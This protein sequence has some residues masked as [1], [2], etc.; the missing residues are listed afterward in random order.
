MPDRMQ[1][2]RTE[3]KDASVARLLAIAGV[4]FGVVFALLSC[5]KSEPERTSEAQTEWVR[6]GG[7]EVGVQLSSRSIR[8]SERLR[9]RLI[10]QCEPS[11]A[12]RLPELT[13]NL[14]SFY[15][16]ESQ[17]MPARLNDA[18]Q[19]V[20]ERVYS[21]EPDQAGV[22]EI[23]PL[24]VVAIPKPPRK[25]APLKV[26][27]KPA[28][29][30]VVSVLNGGKETWRD[31]ATE[32]QAEQEGST[33]YRGLL[34][35]VSSAVL[36]L[37]LLWF[38][39]SRKTTD[40]GNVTRP[41]RAW[42]ALAGASPEEKRNK[43]EAALSACLAQ[44][45][46]LSLRAVDFQGVQALL[47]EKNWDLPGWRERVRRFHQAQYGSGSMSD[48]DAEGLYA[49]WDAWLRELPDF[50]ASCTEQGKEEKG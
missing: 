34:A 20:R 8:T 12:M 28:T 9:L 43:M 35:W 39:K 6:S 19:L 13:E 44:R 5:Q 14:G 2:Q 29:V 18:G 1:D 33:S 7:L 49:M 40:V 30:Q 45:L 46:G 15:V 24:E 32:I 42:E 21:L 23:P 26:T 4:V 25:G 50:P 10:A 11:Y 48:E 37:A 36:A 17:T 41:Q 16:L 38:W 47:D 27:S 3:K 31:I 22:A